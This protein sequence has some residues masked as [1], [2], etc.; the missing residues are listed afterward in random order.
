MSFFRACAITLWFA[1]QSH[2]AHAADNPID[3]AI[4]SERMP[5]DAAQDAFRKPREV[6]SF[7]EIAPGQHALDFFSGPGYYSELMS[8]VVGPTGSVLIYNDELYFQA[9]YHDLMMRLQG[10][11][12]PNA[13]TIKA[14]ANFIELEPKSLDR[15]LFVQ[16]YHDLYWRPTGSPDTLGDAK[17][18]LANLYAALKPGGLVVVLDHVANETSLEDI[19]NIASRLHRIDPRVVRADFEQAG[20]EFI[21]ESD[22]LKNPTDDHLK[23]VFNP[24]IRKRTDQFI[25]KFR[26][27]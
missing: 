26:R 16:V 13:K 8:R 15:V 22:V 19:I 12:L 6:L 4:A 25:Y 18:V 5:G 3:L 11:R 24:A 2:S 1:L 27:P 7:L 23:S 20:F 14:A 17:K 10:K 21:G 9:A